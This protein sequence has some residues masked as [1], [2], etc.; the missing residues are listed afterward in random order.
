M[1]YLKSGLP[2]YI[3]L[4]EVEDFQVLLEWLV[5]LKDAGYDPPHMLLNI[6]NQSE[7]GDEITKLVDLPKTKILTSGGS[8]TSL[9]TIVKHLRRTV[10]GDDW[11]SKLVFSSSYPETQR[12]DSIAEVLSYLLSKNLSATYLDLQKILGAN[13]LSMLPPRPP[14]LNYIENIPSVTAEGIIGKTALNELSRILQIL[15]ARKM[16]F[17][18]SFDYMLA[19][20]KAKIDTSSVVLTVREPEAT[21]GVSLAILGEKDGSI[22]VSGWTRSFSE[23]INDR[24]ADLVSTLTRASTQSSGPIL[25][26]P[27]HLQQFNYV[28]LDGLKVRNPQE[29]LAAL[30]YQISLTDRSGGQILMS[31]EDMRAVDVSEGQLILAFEGGTGQWWASNVQSCEECQNRTIMVPDNDAVLM[32]LTESSVID[33]VKYDGSIIDLECAILGFRSE[34]RMRGA[35]VI[36]HVHL[37]KSELLSGLDNRLLGRGTRIWQGEG[38]SRIQLTLFDAD[39]PLQTGQL[40]RVFSDSIRLVPQQFL[41]SFNVVIC[42]S[43]GTTMSTKDIRMKTLRAV[44]RELAQLTKIAP[45]LDGFISNL[46]S[47]ISRAEAAAISSLLVL[48]SL[49]SNRTEGRLGLVVVGDSPTKFSIQRGDKIQTDVEFS[50]DLSSEEVL[51]STIYSLIDSA[52][53]SAGGSNLSGSFRAIAEYLEDFNSELPTLVLIFTDKADDED[54]NLAPFLQAIS[55]RKGHFI[56]Q[57]G[58]GKNYSLRKA[59]QMLTSTRFK[60]QTLDSISAS[61]FL[62]EI[63]E[64]LESLVSETSHSPSS[65]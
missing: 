24:R 23:A 42:I 32:G 57:F 5:V 49:A 26:S 4:A 13:L 56:L 47:S 15:A 46:G 27:S 36:S 25:N 63:T 35:E 62:G 28:L 48:N 54:E 31:P 52:R 29:I 55:A 53:D 39:P 17:I 59:Q 43:T 65:T 6:Q 40:G 45:D 41:K 1:S 60:I 19:E 37:R 34:G 3:D 20:N 61:L 16:Q 22:K 10:N 8:I 50:A 38:S 14:Y 21:S 12:G 9:S 7:W 30:K 64:S 11:A 44:K 18:E 51:V 58:L 33:I 2:I